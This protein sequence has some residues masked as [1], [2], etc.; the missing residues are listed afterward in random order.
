M[1]SGEEDEEI[2]F[3]ERAKLYR[4]DRELIQWNERGVGDIKILYHPVKKHY[5]VVMRREQVLNVCANHI[6]SQSIKLKPMNT[7]ANTLVWTATD[8]SGTSFTPLLIHISLFPVSSHLH[9]CSHT[10]GHG[11]VEQLAAKFKTAELAESFRQVFTDCKSHMLQADAAQTSAAKAHSRE[12]NPVVFF[13][14]A[15]EGEDAGIIVIE[16]FAHI[17][18]KTAENFR[19]LCTREKGFGYRQSV[20]HR[21]VPG[22]MCQVRV[23]CYYVIMKTQ[24]ASEIVFDS[25]CQNN[26]YCNCYL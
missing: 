15:I 25:Q 8:Y 10:E 19:A 4:W 16:L 2:L 13:N 20:F 24:H 5:R 22:F 17:V 1:K 7:S 6:I 23:H 21:I 11:K 26:H 14:I 12:S 3:K 9:V 18:P